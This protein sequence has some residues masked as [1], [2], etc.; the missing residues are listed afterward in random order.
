[1]ARFTR[2]ERIERPLAEVWAFFDDFSNAPRW[3]TGVTQIELVSPGSKRAGTQFRET[4]TLGGRT[5][6]NTI[7]ISVYQPPRRYVA[8][9]H[10]N[11]GTVRYSYSFTPVGDATIV[12][13][14][15]EITTTRWFTK[16]FEPIGLLMLRKYDGRQLQQLKA[17]IERTSLRTRQRAA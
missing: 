10:S 3:L 13:L 8:S 17:A 1:M 9:A 7:E 2:T 4:R 5:E 11:G 16:I 12:E 6:T 15:A 14:L